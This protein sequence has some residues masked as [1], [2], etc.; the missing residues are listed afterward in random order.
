MRKGILLFLI[1]AAVGVF[2][3]LGGLLPKQAFILSVFSLS[4]L[5][6]LFFWNLR[7]SFVFIG[8]GILFLSHSVDIE[9]FISYAS[10][11]VILFL[12]GMMI[13]VGAMK[14]S[15]VFQLFVTSLMKSGNLSGLKIFIIIGVFSAVLSGLTGEATSIIVMTAII[16]E[17]CDSL[18]VS[19]VPMVISSVMT[20]NIGSAFALLG[21]PVGVLVALRGH[22]TFE[23]FL[24]RALPVS[25]VALIVTI[26]ILCFW[27]RS[28][29]AEVSS[30]LSMRNKGGQPHS[31]DVF[32]FPEENERCYFLH[33][34]I[35]YCI[36]QETWHAVRY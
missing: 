36:T 30:K 27:Y 14:G 31:T 19:R 23:D 10:L 11:D 16:L 25:V 3:H 15:G 28:Y 22:L 33:N 35:A 32:Q 17:I 24:T 26:L 21:N 9:H 13:V 7:L 12:V 4:I 8:S 5:G 29:V 1:S 2:G 6:T 18:E 20:T 34:D